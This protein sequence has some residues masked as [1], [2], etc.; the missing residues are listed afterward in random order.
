[1]KKFTKYRT[2]IIVPIVALLLQSC[3]FCSTCNTQGNGG[4][5]YIFTTAVPINNPEPI[6]YRIDIEDFSIKKVADNCSIYSPPS[7]AGNLAA[8]RSINGVEYLLLIESETSKETILTNENPTYGIS[9]PV[10]SPSDKHIAFHGGSG[11][12]FLYN[13]RDKAI[14]K[15][16]NSATKDIVYSFSNDGNMLAFMEQNGTTLTLKIINT[17]NY[18]N[19]LLSY[20]FNNAN[21]PLNSLQTIS[22]NKFND[23]VVF[24]LDVEGQN[25][26]M[27]TK[28][29]GE[30]NKISISQNLGSS[31]PVISEDENYV[32]FSANDGNIWVR[33][34]KSEQP[35]FIQITNTL[36]SEKNINPLW[37]SSA[38][39]LYYIN[40]INLQGMSAYYSLYKAELINDRDKLKY[41]QS[42]L[43]CN[44]IYNAYWKLFTKN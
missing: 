22:W 12:L 9:Y 27:L 44:N 26:I 29:T 21:L 24:S 36:S 3:D 11:K 33:T 10:I 18:D 25:Y 17:D 39:E 41:N 2:L 16:S 6:V 13:L 23:K 42:T 30:L 37:T 31:S 35:E 14:D 28:T 34:L 7:D 4:G 19:V 5:S 32:A 43:L 40:Q 1:M 38:N 15:I 20:D 8:V